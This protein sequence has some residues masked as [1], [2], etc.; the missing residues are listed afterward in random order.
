MLWV[1]W[2]SP[3]LLNLGDKSKIDTVQAKF[4]PT[5]TQITLRWPKYQSQPSS[6]LEIGN[7]M[8]HRIFMLAAIIYKGDTDLTNWAKFC[9]ISNEEFVLQRAFSQDRMKNACPSTGGMVKHFNSTTENH[10]WR[11][12]RNFLIMK[13]PFSSRWTAHQSHSYLCWRQTNSTWLE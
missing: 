10:A 8:V 2:I 5:M 3:K 7:G 4:N 11:K 6:T 12:R 13:L 9:R 1:A